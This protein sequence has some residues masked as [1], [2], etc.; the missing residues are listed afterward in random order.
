MIASS[1]VKPIKTKKNMDVNS[2]TIFGN[3]KKN[4]NGFVKIL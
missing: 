4:S 1:M 3:V 2:E